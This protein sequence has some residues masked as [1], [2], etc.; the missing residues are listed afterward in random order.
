MEVDR[1]LDMR[2]SLHNMSI[3]QIWSER[4]VLFALKDVFVQGKIIIAK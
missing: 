1:G 4:G 2:I 3:V